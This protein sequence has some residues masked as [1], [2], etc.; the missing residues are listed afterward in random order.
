MSCNQGQQQVVVPTGQTEGTALVAEAEGEG[1]PTAVVAAASDIA[2][3]D[4]TIYTDNF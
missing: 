2:R 4:M 3:T 1:G